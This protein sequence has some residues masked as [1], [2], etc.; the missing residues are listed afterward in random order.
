MTTHSVVE[1]LDVF[2]DCHHGFIAR[3]EVTVVNQ[4]LFEVAPEALG[5]SVVVAIAFSRHRSDH[6]GVLQIVAVA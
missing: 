2:A 6:A 3:V 1:Y 5:W 4:L